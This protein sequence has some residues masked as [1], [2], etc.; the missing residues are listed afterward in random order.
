[1]SS[2][3]L[4]N[5]GTLDKYIGDAIMSFWNAPIMQPDHALLACRAALAMDSAS[6]RSS[7]RLRRTWAR[8]GLLTRIGI[9]TGPMVF[10]NMGS[11]QKFNYSVLGDAVNLG[12][13][14]R[15][16]QQVLWLAH[17]HRRSQRPNSVKDHS[18]CAAR[19]ASREGKAQA[20][21]GL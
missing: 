1:M 16:G 19:S 12:Q 18:F 4:A 17:S 10:G 2:L 3:V 7:R 9:N 11:T 6:A 5:D 14:A 8:S 15:G 20:D 21:G 13:P